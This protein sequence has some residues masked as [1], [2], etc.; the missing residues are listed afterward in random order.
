MPAPHHPAP[1]PIPAPIS[2]LRARL[3]V[4]ERRGRAEAARGVLPFGAP[5]IDACLPGGG[6]RLGA[7]HELHGAGPDTETAAVPALLAAGILARHPGPVLWI[8]PRNRVAGHA[9]L[10]AG[11]DPRRVVFVDAG[12]GVLAAAEDALRFP[13]LAGAV[14]E[15]DGPIDPTASRRLQL[16][17]G[18]SPVLGL[19]IRRSRRF[20]DPAL[21]RPS[22][23]ETRWRVGVLPSSP[24]LPDAPAVP[25]LSRPRWRLELLRCRGGEGADWTV[26]ASDAQGRLALAPL[27]AHGAAAPAERRAA[28]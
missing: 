10:R 11:L 15:L 2:A 6:L 13:G 19:L 7:V 17:A 9:L 28:G 1:I 22:A 4:L 24:A 23:A 21:T 27:L 12:P 5:A 16:A 18:G 20:D 26:E 14:A 8:A 3:A 25:G